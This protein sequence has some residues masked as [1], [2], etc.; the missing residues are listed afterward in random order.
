[1]HCI[2]EIPS[3]WDTQGQEGF[4]EL[5]TTYCYPGTD[6]LLIG[7]SHGNSN[8][9]A[10][11]ETTWL[12]ESK[13]DGLKNAPVGSKIPFNAFIAI[14]LSYSSCLMDIFAGTSGWFESRLD[15]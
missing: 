1:M 10:N 14:T 5:R 11:V 8:S 6:V 12:R 15:R 3:R 13:L 9:F 7:F 4:A 2:A